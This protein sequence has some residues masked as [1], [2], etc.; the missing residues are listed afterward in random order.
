MNPGSFH[1]QRNIGWN[2]PWIDRSYRNPKRVKLNSKGML[3][4]VKVFAETVEKTE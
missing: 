2:E 3:S 4:R 1:I